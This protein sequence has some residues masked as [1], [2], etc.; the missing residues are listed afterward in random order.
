MRSEIRSIWYVSPFWTKLYFYQMTM[1]LAQWTV[2]VWVG[3][4]PLGVTDSLCWL[5]FLKNYKKKKKQ[6]WKKFSE[7][8][9]SKARLEKLKFILKKRDT[10]WKKKDIFRKNIHFTEKMIT[11]SPIKVPRSQC[12]RVTIFLWS[13]NLPKCTNYWSINF[14]KKLSVQCNIVNNR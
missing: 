4:A 6:A 12:F 14:I 3:H 8:W 5:E 1:A 10:L 9:W 13:Q 11:K 7:L 2:I